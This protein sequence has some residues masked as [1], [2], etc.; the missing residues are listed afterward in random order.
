[1]L[2]TVKKVSVTDSTQVVVLGYTANNLLPFRL[3]EIVR[4]Y[5]MGKKNDISKITCIGSIATERV[6]DG[7]VIV[8]LLGLSMLSLTSAIHQS[9]VLKQILLAG[10]VIFS[11][12]VCLLILAFIYSEKIL[13]IWKKHFGLT[14]ITLIEKIIHSISFIR[15]KKILLQIVLLSVSVWLIEGAVLV[16][17]LWAMGFSNFFSAGYFCLAIINLGIL[18]PSAPG[19]VG[20]FQAASVFA[21]LA[22]GY[23]ESAGLAYGLLVHFVQY[24]PITVT[25]AIIF[26]RYG[27]SFKVFYKTISD[28]T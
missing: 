24:V 5:I 4:A 22:L 8:C 9:E 25:G 23:S 26:I 19:Y 28:T 16:I 15:D 13:E 12:S 18:L 2:S 10:G 21:F 1:M 6:I 20:V 27:Y 11:S 7:T 17:I 3:G 14:G